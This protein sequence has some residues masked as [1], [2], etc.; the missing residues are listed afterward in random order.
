MEKEEKIRADRAVRSKKMMTIVDVAAD[1]AAVGI[2]AAHVR[3]T[4]DVRFQAAVAAVKAHASASA[5]EA[6]EGDWIAFTRT[7]NHGTSNYPN[8]GR[9]VEFAGPIIRA[10]KKSVDVGTL[11]SPRWIRRDHVLGVIS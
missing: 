8:L 3:R 1:R 6:S 9:Y 11:G 7:I 2:P 4:R 10:T 5:E